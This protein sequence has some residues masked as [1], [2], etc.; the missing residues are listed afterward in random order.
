MTWREK[1]KKDLSRE[2]TKR[3]MA[4]AADVLGLLLMAAFNGVTVLVVM[5]SIQLSYPE[6]LEFTQFVFY[7]AI[8]GF[9]LAVHNAVISKFVSARI[10][11]IKGWKK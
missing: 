5:L 2:P 10:L 7:V 8:L 11:Q 3:E 1:L 6:G 9:C 4:D